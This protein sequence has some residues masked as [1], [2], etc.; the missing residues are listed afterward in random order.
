MEQTERK[1]RVYAFIDSQNLNVGTQKSGWKMDWRKF[2]QF[3]ADE[4]GV[5]KAY[6]FIGYM[7][8]NEDLYEQMHQAGYAVVLK[9]TFDL[10]RPQ[11][12]MLEVMGEEPGQNN[13]QQKP[14]EH[15]EKKPVKG[16]IDAELVLWAMKEMSNY[17]KAIIVSG[18][19]DFYC[20][21][22]YLDQ[23]GRLLHL[24]APSQYYSNL[25][26]KYEKYVVR[27]DQHRKQLAYKDY[28]RRGSS[29]SGG[30]KKWNGPVDHTKQGEA[31]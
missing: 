2:R 16:N 9:P 30:N 21:I 24:L 7:P 20:L 5:N 13:G 18:D 12:E 23:K 28:N 17:E 14:N 19:G 31:L 3:L 11:P 25:Y 27:L 10:T 8:E 26:N 15:E 29:K 22:E 6:M 1:P 4:Y